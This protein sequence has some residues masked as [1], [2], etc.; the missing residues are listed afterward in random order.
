MTSQTLKVFPIPYT[1]KQ[2]EW[3]NN[4]KAWKAG[5]AENLKTL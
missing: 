2:V 5:I 1:P 3:L 4:L